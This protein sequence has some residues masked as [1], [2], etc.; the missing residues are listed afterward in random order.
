MNLPIPPINPFPPV[1][2]INNFTN[3]DINTPQGHWGGHVLKVG[4]MTLT[5]LIGPQNKQINVRSMDIGI[6]K[7]IDL[8]WMKNTPQFFL[9]R[10]NSKEFIQN[11][12][13]NIEFPS[14]N[15]AKDLSQR[16]SYSLQQLQAMQVVARMKEAADKVGAGF[17][18]GFVTPTGERFLM[19][20]MD[21]DSSQ[22]KAINAKL[23]ELQN[24][25]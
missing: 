23:N 13:N 19:S 4:I 20:N 25:D 3:L 24:R 16:D 15:D 6:T 8:Y 5:H 18:G 9:Y 12:M 7:Q 11:I 2:P 14:N 21:S 22:L 17:V 10:N 1:N